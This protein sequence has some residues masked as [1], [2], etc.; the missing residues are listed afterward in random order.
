MLQPNFTRAVVLEVLRA[1]FLKT[2]RHDYAHKY[3]ENEED[4][5]ACVFR[6]V[7][8]SL[9]LDPRWRVFLSYSTYDNNQDQNLYKPD[10]IFLRGE[11]QHEAISLELLVEVKNWPT[12]TAVQHDLTKL[13]QLRRRFGQ[14]QPE[15][16][17]F[18]VVGRSFAPPAQ[19]AEVTSRLQA[20]VSPHEGVHIWLEHHDLIYKG[21]WDAVNKTDPY[22]EKLRQIVGIES[23]S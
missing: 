3:I 12:Y 9:D 7:R 1:A 19:L 8:E 20:A 2:T 6:Y 13:L 18:A 15:V 22:R 21:P 5:R 4:V 23:Q 17:F 14:D 11:Q 16:V 10:M